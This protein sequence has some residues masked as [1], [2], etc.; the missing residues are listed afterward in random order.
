MT[1]DG[2]RTFMLYEV[3]SWRLMANGKLLAML[4]NE[5]AIRE[6]PVLPGD[7]CLYPAQEHPEF[8]YFFQYRIANKIKERDPEAMA[9][10]SLLIES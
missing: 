1:D 4:V 8:R 5:S 2:F 3:L 9:A 6:T 7:A 10:I